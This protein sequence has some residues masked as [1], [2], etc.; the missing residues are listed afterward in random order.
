ML[1]EASDGDAAEVILI[2]TGSEVQLAVGG[3]RAAGG[4]GHPDPGR[5]DAVPW[6]GSRSRTRAYQQRVLPPAVKARVASRPVSLMGWRELVG[7]AGEI[8]SLEHFGASADVK[9]LFEQFGFT[10]GRRR[11]RRPRQPRAIGA[12]TGTDAPATDGH[13]ND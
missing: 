4:R 1:A 8:V 5:V 6:S 7:D 9:T 2:A 12:I 3:P 10:A 11:R 13:G